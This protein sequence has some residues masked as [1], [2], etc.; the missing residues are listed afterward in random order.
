MMGSRPLAH[1]RLSVGGLGCRDKVEGKWQA[2]Q[3]AAPSAASLQPYSSL[4][5]SERGLGGSRCVSRSVT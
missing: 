1:L 2:A 4:Q 3:G 5:N